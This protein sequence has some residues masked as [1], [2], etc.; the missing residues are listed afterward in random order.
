MREQKQRDKEEE[1]RRQEASELRLTNDTFYEEN[2]PLF[3]FF[4]F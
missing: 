3:C 2:R 4:F 1:K